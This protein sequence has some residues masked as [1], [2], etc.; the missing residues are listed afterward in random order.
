M[1]RKAREYVFLDAIVFGLYRKHSSMAIE[2]C[3]A[4]AKMALILLCEGAIVLRLR[5]MP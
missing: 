3:T 1:V 2:I 4:P 5:A